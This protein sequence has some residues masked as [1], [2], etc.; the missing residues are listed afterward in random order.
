MSKKS[1]LLITKKSFE[2]VFLIFLE[3]HSAVVNEYLK[4]TYNTN[5]FTDSN[6]EIVRTTTDQDYQAIE[7]DGQKLFSVKFGNTY[8]N[9]DQNSRWI[10]ILLIIIS[11]AFISVFVKKQLDE[12]LKERSISFGFL[13]LL[14]CILILRSL[15]LLTG[16]PFDFVYI[17]LFDPKHYASSL[18]NPSLGDLLLNLVSLLLLGFYIFN[19]FLKSSVVRN[20]LSGR[21][22]TR[23][24]VA[25]SC[26]FFSFFW[27]AVHHQ[28]MKTLN[29]DSQWSMDITQNFEFDYF[30]V[31]GFF[32]FFIS[33][34]VYFLFAHVCFRLYIKLVQN[35]GKKFIATLAA[36]SIVFVIFA[37]VLQLDFAVVL[38]VNLLFFL[39]IK[40]F[41]LPKFI[42]KIQYLTFIYFFAFGL[43]G[44][45]I[46][47]YANFQYNRSNLDYNRSRLANQLL[48]E[49]NFY[50]E[51]QLADVAQNIKDDIFIQA[52]VLSPYAS[53]LIIE[54]KIRRMMSRWFL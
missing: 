2:I 46:G 54:K 15:M 42:G 17:D 50:T 5:I 7:L 35:D 41:N 22:K 32:I 18:V 29:F 11:F 28:T 3:E 19:N 34:V 37:L 43:P 12:Y 40:F 25:V 8:S 44:A 23:F 45:I 52:R 51:L 49:S 21:K 10:I 6:I 20:I 38:V 36:G 24:I 39:T 27:L 1:N 31:I 13:F 9:T 16:F 14:S 26:I 48:V 30:K 33:V 47:L 4:N 53:K